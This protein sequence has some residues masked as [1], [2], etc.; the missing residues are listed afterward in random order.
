MNIVMTQRSDLAE[1][2][3]CV[4]KLTLHA[5]QRVL[6]LLALLLSTPIGWGQTVISPASPTA[7][8]YLTPAAVPITLRNALVALGDRLEQPGKERFTVAG[9]Y[10]DNKGS[11]GAKI[12]W[13]LPGKV[14][15]DL[16]GA[17]SHSVLSDGATTAT[18]TGAV[19]P[20][21]D[22]LIESLGDDRAETLLYGAVGANFPWR[23]LGASF[24]TDDG[25]TKNYTGPFYD[26]HQTAAAARVRSDQAPR[27]KF[28]C[29]DS[30]TSLLAETRYEIERNGTQVNVA[31][32]Y[33]GW[34]SA[35]G[36]A[37]PGQ[38]I[39]RENGAEVFRI[40]VSSGQVS[41]AANDGVFTHP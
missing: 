14:R 1:W 27:S 39:R 30:G 40:Q 23:F 4:A 37:V 21:D 6:P 32:V 26:I 22:D 33:T 9:T 10:T 13:E 38:I 29:F 36:Q 20:S 3:R 11:Q 7:P 17:F 25:T 2:P 41:S 15:I 16:T 28:F 18:N 12:T 31:T 5:R 34:S 35:S 19:S 24:R 8:Q